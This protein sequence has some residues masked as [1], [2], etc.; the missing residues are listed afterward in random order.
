MK[1]LSIDAFAKINLY[2]D[3]TGKLP[4]NYHT[5]DTVM[6]SVSLCDT[7]S[8]E[9][10]EGGGITIECTN[11]D[12][13]DEDNIAVKA[14]RKFYEKY[15]IEEAN[16]KITIEKNIPVAAGLAG[17]STNAAAVL[18]LLNKIYE[19]GL[20]EEELCEIG[21]SLGA[22]IPFC[23]RG[24]ISRAQGIG[25]KFSPCPSL[26]AC[27]FVIAV[28]DETSQTAAAYGELDRVGYS[29]NIR[30]DG[31]NGC[32][33]FISAVESGNL[34]KIADSMYNAFELTV[35]KEN[36]TAVRIK[37]FFCENGALCA[38]MSGSGPSIFALY[39][40]REAAKPAADA[41]ISQGYRAFV[42]LPNKK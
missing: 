10:T 4:N 9:K 3:V 27:A 34:Q 29:G 20:S 25:E 23:I 2:L 8:V 17:G 28:G 41:L 35:L 30:E 16:I 42:C 32:D 7:V 40:S 22:D 18:I 38:V 21:T 33:I 19:T 14:A 26:P 12:V 15:G 6:Q 24:G 1:K 5:L 39:P 13:P 11:C 31:Q 37:N 36:P